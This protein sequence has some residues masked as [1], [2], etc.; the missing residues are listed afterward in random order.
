MI[1]KLIEALF[2]ER[3]PEHPSLISNDMTRGDDTIITIVPSEFREDVDNLKKYVGENNWKAGLEISLYLSELLLICP[4]KRRRSDS[5]K[6]LI[7]YLED[8]LRIKLI[9]KE[10]NKKNEN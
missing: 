2:G 5:F 7:V 1:L 8:E 10:R 9:I 6:K 4:H 3:H